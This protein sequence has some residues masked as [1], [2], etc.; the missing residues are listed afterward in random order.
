MSGKVFFL[1]INRPHFPKFDFL[2]V[3]SHTQGIYE[4]AGYEILIFETSIT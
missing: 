1:G 2:P 4:P 3:L